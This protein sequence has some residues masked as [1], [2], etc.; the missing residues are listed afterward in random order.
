MIVETPPPPT[1]EEDITCPRRGRYKKS[2]RPRVMEAY[3][4]IS[5]AVVRE[6]YRGCIGFYIHRAICSFGF[7]TY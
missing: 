2:M 7:L 1:N 5:M 3:I 6:R 4:Y